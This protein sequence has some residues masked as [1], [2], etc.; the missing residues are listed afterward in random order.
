MRPLKANP[1]LTRGSSVTLPASRVCLP[2]A[3]IPFTPPMPG[4]GTADPTVAL[5]STAHTANGKNMPIKECGMC[6][7]SRKDP[8][9]AKNVCHDRQWEKMKSVVFLNINT[10]KQIILLFLRKKKFPLKTPFY[11][12]GSV[13]SAFRTQIVLS[14]GKNT[15]PTWRWWHH[16]PRLHFFLIVQHR[17]VHDGSALTRAHQFFRNSVQRWSFWGWSS[18]L[19]LSA[20]EPQQGTQLT[21]WS[22]RVFDLP[23]VCPRESLPHES[24]Y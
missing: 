18:T 9:N 7:T 19:T 20:E 15:A 4:W 10:K 11:K 1:W 13:K 6:Q 17:R 8:T 12:E 22:S 23:Y 21:E 3:K 2:Q 16:S 14:R 5:H 24:Q